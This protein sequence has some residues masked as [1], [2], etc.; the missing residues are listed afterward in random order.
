MSGDPQFVWLLVIVTGLL[1]GWW[2]TVRP[3]SSYHGAGRTVSVLIIAVAILLCLVA[4]KHQAG[5]RAAYAAPPTLA[6]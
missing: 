6:P 1:A 2:L 4:I 3:S 5:P